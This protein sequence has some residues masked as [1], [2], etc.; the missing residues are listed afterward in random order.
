V[1]T[2]DL[3]RVGTN[4]RKHFTSVRAQ[5]GRILSDDDHN[6]NERIHGEDERITRVH[7]IGPAG[8][9]D[10]GFLVQNPTVAANGL[11]DFQIAPGTFYLGGNRLEL[12]QAEQFQTQSDWVNMTIADRPA[13]PA[14]VSRFDLVYL[15]CWLQPVS[16]I[17]DSELFEIAL[18][19]PD[20]SVRMRLMRRVR[21][22]AGGATGDCHEDWATVTGQWAAAG[23][24]TLNAQD[25][26]VVDTL[27]QVGFAA[28]TSKQDLC[29]PPAAGG[30]LGA[31]NQAIRLQFVDATHF[32]WG[33]DNAAPLYRV[34]IG[35][36][37]I[38]QLR[39]VTL[40]TAPKDQAHWPVAG[41][42]VEVLPWSAVLANHE[43]VA[44]VSG[45]LAR[46]DVSYD[47]DTQ[48]LFL[49]ADV[50][51]GFGENWLT[52]PDANGLKPEFFFLRVWDRGTDITSPVAIPFVTGT[53]TALGHTGLTATFTG[54]DHHPD[55]FWIIA[56]RPESPNRVVP[57]LLESGRG[58]HGFRRFYAPLAVIQWTP[59]GSSATGQVIHD[60][61]EKFPPLTRIRTCC[62]YTVGD[63]TQS[64]GAF[65]KIQDAIDALPADGGE[66]CLLPGVYK[67]N[68]RIVN[69]RGVSVHG[70]GA[71][72]VLMDDG[73]AKGPV[74]T[75]TDSQH[76]AIRHLA[77]LAP[78]VLGIQLSSS[79]PAEK[80]KHG[81]EA[82][83][84]V[85]LQIG[86]RDQ[87]A[88]ACRGG[89][90]IRICSCDIEAQALAVPLT[91]QA[92]A[93]TAPLVFVRADDVLIEGNRMAAVFPRRLMGAAGGLQLGGGSERVQIRRNLISGGNGNGIT[94]GSI[95]FVQLGAG[96]VPVPP[97]PVTF[98]Q[99]SFGFTIDANG[100]IHPDPDPQPP[101]GP[102]GKPL[103]PVS[104][105]DLADI[106]IEENDIL[107]MGLCGI[108][109]LRFFFLGFGPIVV[110]QLDVEGNRIVKCVQLEL[111]NQRSSALV[112]L[113]FG[114]ISLLAVE[115]FVLRNNRIERNG[116]SFI[117]PV[118]GVFVGLG[119]GMNIES[120]VIA[121]NGPGVETNQQPTAGLRGGIVILLAR[122][123]L[124]DATQTAAALTPQRDG[125][126]AA[127]IAGN[128][129][130]APL[131]RALY[132]G[133]LGL[134]AV[135]GNAM[136]SLGVAQDDAV[137]GSAVTIIDLGVSFELA[138]LLPRLALAGKYQP[139][140]STSAVILP[141]PVLI[142][143]KVLFND[144]QVLLAPESAGV[145]VVAS[146]IFILT[147]DHV[148]M[149]GNQC[150]AR[151]GAGQVL[152]TNA[153]VFGWSVHVTDNRFE[154]RLTSPGLSALSFA[155]LN[156]TT[157]NLGTRCFFI[158][159]VPTLTVRDPNRSLVAAGN[160]E[161]CTAFSAVVARG[162]IRTGLTG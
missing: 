23:L 70:C 49:A 12:E 2:I 31:E 161:I 107:D 135:H 47:P 7:V 104:D 84:L 48:E 19:G 149:D 101:N 62:T 102:D 18:G 73:N 45:F 38:G 94:L 105:G 155:A 51:A 39:K 150:D 121:D 79:P 120:N 71:H 20:T 8:S 33:F 10:S 5:M 148:L 147:F 142:G 21:V 87:G 4:Y 123:P 130:I 131:G 9:P 124:S 132:L 145:K 86:V 80:D 40:Q 67:E 63:G 58:P 69:R 43:K 83:D 106:R 46:V 114:G 76:I 126:P 37:S 110:R 133:A 29:T 108:A 44:E 141:P 1:A 118:C 54:N 109:T 24:G 144:N 90:L 137:P 68:F 26:L 100:C 119:R 3:S 125:F 151:T 127:R 34:T 82:I 112:S 88:V 66:V 30:Y 13:A 143:G 81:L 42:I 146:S 78:A 52:R 153:G 115:D 50:P 56:A 99:G 77:I 35:P 157:D 103:F 156:C 22:A 128:T 41:Q 136:T 57:W 160:S 89:R 138:G 154:E 27:L 158:F 53:P 15:E 14:G 60:C 122:A 74:I 32:T 91:P 116:R 96:G 17:E 65:A 72:T 61:R 113:G 25:E 139:A 129:V 95:T 117:E 59:A 152:Q 159:G 85:A 6:D 93:G 75:I 111:G 16:A 11:I 55:D 28:G 64:F 98:L 92:T 97:G 36:N 162:L 134:V 140:A